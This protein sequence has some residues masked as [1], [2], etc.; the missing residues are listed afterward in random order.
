MSAA[1]A[2]PGLLLFGRRAGSVLLA[3]LLLVAGVW[4]SWATAQHVVFSQ[5]REQGTLTVARCEGEACTGSF[6]PA[7]P[8]GKPRGSVVIDRSIGEHKGARVPVAV[9]PGTDEVVRT[10]GP[11]FLHAWVP[12]G[13]ALLLA[14]VV[15]GGGLRSARLAWGV[16]LTGGLL[17]VASFATL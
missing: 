13:G 15:L 11:G 8:E 16:G 5:D 12:L 7:D 14:A 6:A 2:Q 9:K 17:L 1:T 10:G 3:L 4:T